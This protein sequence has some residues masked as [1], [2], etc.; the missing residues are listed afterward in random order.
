MFGFSKRASPPGPGIDLPANVLESLRRLR[1]D[2]GVLEPLFDP[3][4]S[5]AYV[6][7]FK[8]RLVPSLWENMRK[9]L[10][11]L[12][13][14]PAILGHDD[15]L[16]RHRQ[17]AS[18]TTQSPSD[19]IAQAA[20]IRIDELLSQFR[21][22][23]LDPDNPNDTGPEEG[24]LIENAEPTRPFYSCFDSL[25]RKAHPRV[26]IGLFPTVDGCE[27][28]AHLGFGNW[29]ACPKPH[30]HVAV[31]KHWAHG[32]GAELVAVTSDI[33]ELRTVR[34]PSTRDEALLLAR[35]QFYYC[36][37]IVDQGVGSIATLAKVLMEDDFW[38]FWWD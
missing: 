4:R 22:G 1:I 6:L 3:P 24:E 2:L 5:N 16:E 28:P 7:P 23:C 29:N 21:Q 13:Y 30:E 19:I 37:D 12:G 25:S 31:L 10:P 8:G 11:P 26:W 17:F 34:R 35:E 9:E 36:T 38:F 15:S 18:D 33:I 32:Y 27:V 20:S 14:W